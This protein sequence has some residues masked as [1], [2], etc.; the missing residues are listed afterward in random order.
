MTIL[1]DGFEINESDLGEHLGSGSYKAAGVYTPNPDYVITKSHYAIEADSESE[2]MFEQER[3]CTHRL[4]ALGVGVAPILASGVVADGVQLFAAN[5]MHRYAA[6]N[7]SG[8]SKKLGAVL[9]EKTVSS[10]LKLYTRLEDL[11]LG[12]W[13]LQFLFAADGEAVVNDPG[14]LNKYHSYNFRDNKYTIKSLI[15]TARYALHCRETGGKLIE[16]DTYD[17]ITTSRHWVQSR[18]SSSAQ[19]AL[20]EKYPL[21][22]NLVDY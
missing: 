19:R 5:L 2:R 16:G 22:E 6:S 21:L 4:R 1:D 18:E 17:L 9:S 10:L 20:L 11:H 14:G 12:I 15:G 3:E 8:G 7:R 13:D